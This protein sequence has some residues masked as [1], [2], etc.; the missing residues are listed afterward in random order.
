MFCVSCVQGEPGKSGEKGL[1]GAPGLR[2]SYCSINVSKAAAETSQPGLI[3][4]IYKM[5]VYRE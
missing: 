3:C 4:V 1:G 5:Y 2:V